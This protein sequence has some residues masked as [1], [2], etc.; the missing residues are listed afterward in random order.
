MSV[1]SHL[2]ELL[3]KEV[4]RITDLGA[5][6]SWTLHRAVLAD[7]REVFVK[8]ADNQAEVLA[9]EAAGLRWLATDLVP[10]VLAADDRM[11][12]LPWLAEATPTAATAERLGSELA[13][14]HANSPA[15]FG[16]PWPGWIADLPLDNTTSDDPWRR[17]YAERRLAPYLPRAAAHLGPDGIRL[18]EQIIENIDALS[19]PAEPPSRIHGDL[20]SGN[21][22]WTPDRAILIDPAAHGGHRETD[23]A[24]LAL[25]G[26]PHLD[27]IR[28]AYHET[29][30]LADGWRDRMPLHQLHPLLV[31]VVLFGSGYRNQT[32]AAATAV[33][34]A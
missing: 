11:L 23:L 1:A 13:A 6:H 30:P 27:R 5:S 25:F 24:M 16:A 21:I 22:R 12:V 3:G 7:G 33:L 34:A 20:W 10:E 28:A 14:L 29:H 26:A 15:W 31:H 2:G 9:A 19:S 4:R 17:W 18:L 8:A 32:L